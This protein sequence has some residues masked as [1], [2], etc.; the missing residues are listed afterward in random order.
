MAETEFEG[1]LR[2]AKEAHA[3]GDS[4]LVQSLGHQL[5]A[6]AHSSWEKGAARSVLD[7]AANKGVTNA[8][9]ISNVA[10]VTV[11]NFD[12]EFGSLVWLMVKIAIAAIPALI[13]LMGIAFVVV[14]GLGALGLTLASLG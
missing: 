14:L 7:A 3:Q 5:Q 11:V 8:T 10:R 6:I 12:M 1:L 9:T 13:I 2:G 4:V